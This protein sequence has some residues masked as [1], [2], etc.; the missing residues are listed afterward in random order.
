MK[1]FAP[2]L[3]G[4]GLKCQFIEDRAPTERLRSRV[5]VRNGSYVRDAACIIFT[6]CHYK[7]IGRHR[8]Q[9]RVGNSNKEQRQE[10]ARRAAIA[11]WGK[12]SP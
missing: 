6:V 10:W 2:V 5:P 7:K 12:G 9:A 1:S 4:L 8:A 3:N 11:W